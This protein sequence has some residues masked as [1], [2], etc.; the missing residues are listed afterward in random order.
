MCSCFL[1][2]HALHLTLSCHGTFF[3]CSIKGVICKIKLKK[4]AIFNRKIKCVYF[5]FFLMDLFTFPGFSEAEVII[6]STY[7]VLNPFATIVKE[8][9]NFSVSMTKRSIHLFLRD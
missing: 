7:I 4:A 5:H 2:I 1:N 6:G 8:K 9:D 3:C